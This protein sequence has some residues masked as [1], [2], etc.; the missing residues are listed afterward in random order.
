MRIVIIGP[1]GTGKTTLAKELSERNKIPFIS[2]SAKDL[3]NCYGFKNHNDI[4][5]CGII[6]PKKG[7]QFQMELIQTRNELFRTNKS[8]ISDRSPIDVWVYFLLQNSSQ[9]SYNQCNYMEENFRTGLSYIDKIIF[10][11]FTSSIEIENDGVRVINPYFQFTVNA[12]FEKIIQDLKERSWSNKVW[13]TTERNF[14]R[15]LELCNIWLNSDTQS[16]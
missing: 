12:L 15:K 8:F 10:L 14:E 13:R 11:P 16:L 9:L 5:K 7:L 4:V 6:D 1:S 2:A 3:F